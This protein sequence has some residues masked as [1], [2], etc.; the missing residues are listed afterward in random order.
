MFYSSAGNWHQK[1]APAAG[2]RKLVSVYG[3]LVPPCAHTED[4]QAAEVSDNSINEKTT[5]STTT[6]S[7]TSATQ[8]QIQQP[9][10]STNVKFVLWLHVKVSR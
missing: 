4:L 2:T 10:W 9:Q 6:T 7:T 3:P 1:L 8:W 5:Q